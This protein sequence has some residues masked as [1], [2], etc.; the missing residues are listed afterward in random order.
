MSESLKGV[1]ERIVYQ[2][3]ENHYTIGEFRPEGAKTVTI[4]GGMP[5][6]QCGETLSLEGEWIQ[7]PVHGAQF[8]VTRFTA[9]LPAS[10]YGI[11]K[12]LGSGLIPHIGPKYAERIVDKFGEDTL[13]VI[14]EESGKLRGVEGIGAKRAKL[15]KQAWDEQS[16][17]REVMVFLQT[18]GV[19]TAL[20][21]RLI[22]KYGNPAKTILQNEPYRVAREVPGIGFKTADKIA[23]NLGFA[24][25]SPERIDAGLLYAL[26]ELEGEGHTAYDRKELVEY[27]ARLLEVDLDLLPPRLDDLVKTEALIEV[28]SPVDGET[29]T[30]LQLPILSK[31]EERIARHL[32]DLGSGTSALPPIKVAKAVEWAQE[33]AGFTFAE[34][35]AEGVAAALQNKVSVLTGGPG[36]GKTTI[37]RALVEIL[38]LKKVRVLLAAPTGRAAQ[39]MSESTGVTAK[40]IHR[41][42]EWDPAQ[43]GFSRNEDK[44]LNA[45]FVIVDEASMLDTRLA[46][47]LLRAVPD[48][49]HLLL[50]GDVDQLP[51]VGAGNVLKDVIRFVG[52]RRPQSFSVTR[53]QRIFRQGSRSGIVEVSHTIL[54]GQASPPPPA[55][56]PDQIDAAADLHFI[57]APEPERCLGAVVRL[58]KTLL[59]KWYEWADPA[60]DIQVL[61]PLHKGQAGI[62]N[63]NHEL[64]SALNPNGSSVGIGS[65]RYAVGDKVIQMRNNYDLGIFNGDLGRIT[66]VNTESGTL[67]A[68]FDGR[69]VDFERSDLLDLAPAYAISI[70][71]SQGSEF[72]IVVIPLLKQHYIMLQRNLVYT[73]ITR[74]RRK[75]FLVGDPAAYAMA[76]RNAESGQRVTDLTR[77]LSSLV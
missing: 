30:V 45:G 67:A 76:V 10:V 77:K 48:R 68:D 74:G 4:V 5:G 53:L 71:K 26:G 28:T 49:A 73:G 43:G 6:A 50:V 32:I 15:I 58:C 21:L 64:Q 37:L 14:S 47:S 12:Y 57:L 52:E 22:R 63:L 16:A 8:K 70:H 41:L 72:P 1:L 46:A 39:R 59:P 56:A 42:L 61:A 2:N 66:H 44:P 62:G 24:N 25:E 13:R 7:H 20:C 31:A 29:K 75:V 9:E 17:L 19:S 23:R 35:Q 38:K 11:R 40:T 60:M 33:Q 69:V 27:T 65:Q 51:S 34:E 3:E 36:T 54:H 18:Y 55:T